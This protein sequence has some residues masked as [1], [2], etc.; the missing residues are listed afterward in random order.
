MGRKTRAFIWSTTL[1][2]AAFWSGMIN[3]AGWQKSLLWAAL[4]FTVAMGSYL[5]GH[6]DGKKSVPRVIAVMPKNIMETMFG[7]EGCGE[8]C[9]ECPNKDECPEY[10]ENLKE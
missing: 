4:L 6:T 1:G 2:V 7:H 3:S 8:W 5:K 9:E 10:K